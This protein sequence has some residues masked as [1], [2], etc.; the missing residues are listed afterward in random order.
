M[1]WLVAMALG[2]SACGGGGNV[3][4]TPPPTVPSSPPPTTPSGQ[5]PLDA[6]LALTHT[7]DA[8]SLG[9]TGAGVTIGVVDSGIMRNHPALAGRVTQELIYVDPATNNTAIDDVVGHGTWV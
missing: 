5:P 7:Y 9:Y 3:R 1:A 4:P 8:H 6:Q 2:L